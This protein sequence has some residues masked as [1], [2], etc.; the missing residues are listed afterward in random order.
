M[1]NTNAAWNGLVEA[2]MVNGSGAEAGIAGC[3]AKASLPM[4][5]EAGANPLRTA[6]GVE[7]NGVIVVDADARVVQVISTG[8]T[9]DPAAI[10]AAVDALLP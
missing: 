9:G 10:Q 3:G 6:L 2:F 8:V 5:Q 4:V 1:V 7:Y